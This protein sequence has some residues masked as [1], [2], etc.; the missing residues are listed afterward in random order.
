MFDTRSFLKWLS[1]LLIG[2]ATVALAF[3][4]DKL[5]AFDPS[6]VA[7]DPLVAG[8]VAVVVAAAV[9]GVNWLV[10]KLPA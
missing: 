10:G 3:V 2:L 7:S 5:A 8:V 6:T 4:G 9:R 1:A